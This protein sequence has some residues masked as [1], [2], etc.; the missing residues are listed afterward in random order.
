M[1]KYSGRDLLYIILGASIGIGV[2]FLGYGIGYANGYADGFDA[3]I[4]YGIKTAQNM[5][6]LDID[7]WNIPLKFLG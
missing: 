2:M 3:A 4:K 7:M 1:K 6:I 5:G